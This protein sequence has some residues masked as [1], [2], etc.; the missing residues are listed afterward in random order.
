LDFSSYRW[1][2]SAG[3]KLAV[4]PDEN[5]FETKKSR[6]R[7]RESV[8]FPNVAISLMA[9][10]KQIKN[11]ASIVNSLFKEQ[12]R[13]RIL[14]TLPLQVLRLDREIIFH[15][16]AL[17]VFCLELNLCKFVEFMSKP[18]TNV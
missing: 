14:R 15:S 13:G 8:N 12:G 9:F 3:K 7:T 5:R 16:L 2:Q 10:A 17:R 4:A 1:K 18:F 6:R 11:P